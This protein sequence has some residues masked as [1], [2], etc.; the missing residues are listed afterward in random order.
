MEKKIYRITNK[1]ASRTSDGYYISWTYGGENFWAQGEFYIDRQ[2]YLHHSH[3]TK[4][5]KEIEF[6][7]KVR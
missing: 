7:I 4:T 2:G 3:I 5:G 1:E 6:K